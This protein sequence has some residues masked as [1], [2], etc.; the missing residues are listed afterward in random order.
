MLYARI[1][2]GLGVLMFLALGLWLLFKPQGL[3][4]FGIEARNAGGRTELRAWYGGLE[5]ALAGF[6]VLGIV[7]PAMAPVACLLLALMSAG[8]LVGRLWGFVAD[9]SVNSQML[10]IAAIEAG[11]AVAGWIGWSRGATS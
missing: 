7:R 6:L 3:E 11:F 1:V 9:G 4:S 2:L 5:V 8:P 10:V